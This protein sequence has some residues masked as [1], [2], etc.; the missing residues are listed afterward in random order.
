MYVHKTYRCGS[1]WKLQRAYWKRLL[2]IAFGTSLDVLPGT[3][4]RGSL[5]KNF[6]F[7]QTVLLLKVLQKASYVR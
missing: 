3:S 6:Y 1:V 4:V 7:F 2:D 5:W